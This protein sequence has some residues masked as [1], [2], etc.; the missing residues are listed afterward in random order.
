MLHLAQIG[1]F[2]PIIDKLVASGCNIESILRSC[3]LNKYNLENTNN[4]VPMTTL[5]SFLESTER[6]HGLDGFL[7]QFGA[8]IT[9]DKSP[10]FRNLIIDS[11]DLI[12]ACRKAANNA[13]I[14][15]T[16][17]EAVFHIR[18]PYTTFGSYFYDINHFGHLHVEALNLAMLINVF[19]E[20]IG[21]DWN[22]IEIHL[23][24]KTF[25][26]VGSLLTGG[27][28]TKVYPE[29]PY[30]AV[31]FPTELLT[32]P[33]ANY[34]PYANQ[35]E[36]RPRRSTSLTLKINQLLNSNSQ[37][38]LP[39]IEHFANIAD[40]NVRTLQRKLAAEGTKF[41]T[42]VDQWRFK[43]AI[44]LLSNPKVLLKDIYRNLGYSDVS[45]FE[46]AF[47]RWTNTTPGKYRNSLPS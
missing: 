45:N 32:K 15:F 26:G 13:D 11:P 36:Y 22:P 20:L 3:E 39:N 6:R 30:T 21:S 8:L 14:V 35:K 37:E 7:E 25:I 42:I 16:N 47:R 33:L 41:S 29:Q 27:H 23:Q 31:T 10:D 46:R 24:Q 17:E 5:C 1:F 38:L 4:Y 28:K 18:G 34:Y 2:K 40:M 43:T 9:L 19:R 12:T 44:D